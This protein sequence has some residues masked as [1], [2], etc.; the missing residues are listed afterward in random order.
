MVFSCPCKRCKNGKGKFPLKEI[1]FHLLKN[2]IVPT[3]TMWRFH[4]ERSVGDKV[5]DVAENVGNV[6]ENIGNIDD[7]VVDIG[8]NVGENADPNV[9]E[10]PSVDENVRPHNSHNKTRSFY[11]RAREPL[12]PS[13]PKGKTALY[14]AIQ[15]NNIKTQ[16]GFS[17]NGVTALL[18]L[19]KELLPEDNTLPS[20]YLM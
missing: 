6:G 18:E 20:K 1:S 11:E 3:Y 14:A 9:D 15:L 2:G 16:Y 19:M 7:N 13:C 12:Y 5:R 8:K 17:D 4:G 10:N